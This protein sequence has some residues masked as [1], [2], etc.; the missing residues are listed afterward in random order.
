[1]HR[2]KN[3]DIPK[4]FTELIK[5]PKNKYTTS[6]SVWGP[7]LQYDFLQ[8][9]EKEIQSYSLFKKSVMSK[10]IETEN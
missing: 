10:L 4:I 6:I 8:N 7:K 5:K 1:M 3:D 2:F 9:K